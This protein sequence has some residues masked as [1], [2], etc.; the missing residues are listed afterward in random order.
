M[1]TTSSPR[2]L[3]A[4]LASV[5]LTAIF[6]ITAQQLPAQAAAGTN[7]GQ[8]SVED[9]SILSDSCNYGGRACFYKDSGYPSTSERRIVDIYQDF[10]PSYTG[11]YWDSS[12]QNMNDSLT[13]LQGHRQGTITLYEHRDQG[14]AFLRLPA[15]DWPSTLS[16]RNFNDI[17]SSHTWNP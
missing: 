10:L 2:R 9:N 12:T 7:I 6:A 13:S 17:T 4:A 11:Y 16:Q 5:V 15:Y 3:L 8:L 14:V 1:P